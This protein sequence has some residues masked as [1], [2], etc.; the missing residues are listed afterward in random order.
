MRTFVVPFIAIPARS[1]AR[2]QEMTSMT[3]MLP[4][5]RTAFAALFVV[6]VM[7][8]AASPMPTEMGGARLSAT[9][10]KAAEAPMLLGGTAAVRRVAL[11]APSAAEIARFAEERAAARAK[12]STAAKRAGPDLIGFGREVPAAERSIPLAKLA[13][14][15]VGG[16]TRVARIEVASAEARGLRVAVRLPGADPGVEVRFAAAGDPA[17]LIGVP[18]SLV[19]QATARFGEY[20]SP[21]A[22]GPRVA[23]ELVAKAGASTTAGT[24]ELV[25]VSHLVV[26]PR[27]GAA[28]EAKIL[29]DIGDSGSCNINYKCVTPFDDDVVSQAGATGKLTFTVPT[30]GTGRCTGTMLNDQ[31]STFTPYIFSANHCFESAYE[32]FTLN[33]WWFFDAQ[34]CGNGAVGNYVQQAGGAALLARSQDWDWALMRLNTPPPGGTYFSGWNSASVPPGITVE[35]YH[36]PSGDLK[37]YSVGTSFAETTV[38]FSLP[39]GG[40]GLFTRVVWD[41]GTTEGGSSGGALVTFGASGYQVRGGLLG[42]S[43]LCSNPS[44]SD[45]YSLFRNMLVNVREYLT[46][47]AQNPDV[48]PVVE[49]YNASL[50]KFFVTSFANEIALLDSG[51]VV[52]W[53]RTGFR[54]LAY[55]GPGAGRSPVCRYYVTPSAGSSHFYSAS[56]QECAAVAQQFGSVWILETSTAFY[57]Q[58]PNPVSGACPAGTRPVYRFFKP[59]ALNHRF[60]A[61]QTVAS[62]LNATAGWIAE[63]FGPGP[64]LPSMCSPLGT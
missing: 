21:V 19:Q 27:T 31:G 25:R 37:K 20:W 54:F 41:S 64:L 6:P 43:A 61:E 3:S 12:T 62:E 22:D 42:G 60:P 5:V 53:E 24:L 59:A 46:P 8:L 29:S 44:G 56:P 36:H 7:A 2:A 13:W 1:P 30:G 9:Q 51:T 63:G 58:V 26:G 38:G 52:G 34:S 18:A 16:G 40:P 28:E 39:A 50:G 55:A 47:A 32:A 45:Y 35:A 57:M 33:V 48:V 49:Y 4:A 23:I 11:A 14:T 10:P 15:T 17:A